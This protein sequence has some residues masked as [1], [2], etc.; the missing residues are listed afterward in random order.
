MRRS[1]G[2]AG[3]VVVFEAWREY[4]RS[5]RF[6]ERKDLEETYK[7]ELKAFS[8]AMESVKIAEVH[9]SR[10][11]KRVDVYT[12]QVFYENEETKEIAL[13]LPTVQNYLPSNFVVP[14]MP[15]ALPPWEKDKKTE[16]NEE[17]QVVA[18]DASDG[19]G[20]VGGGG[21]TGTT[22]GGV[23]ENNGGGNNGI[24]HDVV[25]APLVQLQH[26]L[27]PYTLIH[28]LFYVLPC[29]PLIHPLSQPSLTILSNI[30]YHTLGPLPS[31]YTWPAGRI[32]AKTSRRC[33]LRSS[34]QVMNQSLVLTLPF[35]SLAL[36]FL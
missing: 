14:P 15:T 30:P 10:W 27:L 8:T 24:V 12:D 32:G 6:R 35:S 36:R 13:D 22:V 18:G 11:Q 17:N 25:L 16:N 31:A 19:S 7:N 23:Q 21:G 29:S 20:D 28:E 33:S 5:K 1:L 26:A 3:M 9:V 4:V 34:R 2:A